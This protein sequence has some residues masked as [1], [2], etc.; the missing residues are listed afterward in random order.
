MRPQVDPEPAYELEPLDVAE[1]MDRLAT[2]SALPDALN[3]YVR[4]LTER[5]GFLFNYRDQLR[6]PGLDSLRV[7][8]WVVGTGATGWW[9]FF[10]SSVPWLWC[11]AGLV[12]AGVVIWLLAF[13]KISIRHSIEIHPD[14]MIVDGRFFSADLIGDNW[15]QFQMKGDDPNRLVLCGIYGTRFI[16]YAAANRIGKNDR[17]P[18]TLAK[19]LEIAMDQLWGRRDAIFAAEN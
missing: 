6:N 15:P 1:L 4:I 14:G 18:E 7:V 11:I 9:L 19:D 10:E 8:A 5:G 12:I 13:W 16:E 17:M 2:P 3:G